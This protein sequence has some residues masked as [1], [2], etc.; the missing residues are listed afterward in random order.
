LLSF[1][2]QKQTSG[3]LLVSWCRGS[4]GFRPGGF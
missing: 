3:Q 1:P 4:R 2:E